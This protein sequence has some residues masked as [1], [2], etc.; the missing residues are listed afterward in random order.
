V[1]MMVHGQNGLQKNNYL[2]RKIQNTPIYKHFNC[3]QS[4]IF[5]HL[6]NEN[7]N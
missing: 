7:K 4:V 2:P 3:N 1:F 6:Y 5:N